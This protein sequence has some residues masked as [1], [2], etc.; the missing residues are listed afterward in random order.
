MQTKRLLSSEIF[1]PGSAVH[2]TRAV[3][4]KKP[5]RLVHDH[6][7][8]EVFWLHHGRARHLINGAREVLSE[9][10][11]VFIRPTDSHGLQG[12]GE[13]TH[14]VNIAFPAP[15]I[16]A[17]AARHGLGG[18]F[19]WSGAAQPVQ[20]HRDI[21]QLAE[22]SRAAMRLE[23]GVR[24]VLAAE[25][26]LLPLLSELQGSAGPLPEN[27]P[28]W[29]A[30]ACA[31]AHDPAV[32]R[33]GSAGLVRVAGRAHAHVSRTMQ[34]YFGETPSDYVNR[35]RMSHAAMALTGTSDPL[36]EIAAECGLPNLSHFHRLFRAQHGLP[37]AEYRRKFQKNVIQPI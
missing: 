18:R 21:R 11:M 26:F 25:A 12:M 24:S 7:F 34:R 22:L 31:A 2:F 6:D 9:G 27:L 16:D 15:L 35:I 8:H 10:N 37:P 36:A 5:I 32:F 33:D 29:L 20:V 14:L 28:D 13:E 4:S 1:Q 30:R 19:F 23:T 3:L 17:I